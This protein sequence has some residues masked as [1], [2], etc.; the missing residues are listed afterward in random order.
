MEARELGLVA[1]VAHREHAPR[2]SV[3]AHI[4]IKN[5]AQRRWALQFRW[6]LLERSFIFILTGW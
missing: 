1:H 6:W 2:C 3:N 4:G 5:S